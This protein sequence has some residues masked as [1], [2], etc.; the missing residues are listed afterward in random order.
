MEEATISDTIID[1]KLKEKEVIT[2]RIK[3]KQNQ[4]RNSYLTRLALMKN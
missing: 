4:A 2:I 1:E 3:K